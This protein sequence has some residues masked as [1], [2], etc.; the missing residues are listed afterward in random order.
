MPSWII[1]VLLAFLVL[2]LFVLWRQAVNARGEAEWSATQVKREAQEATLA[3]QRRSEQ[4]AAVLV[5]A[6]DPIV[7]LSHEPKILNLNPAAQALFG[8]QAALGQ[9]LMYATRSGEL[10]E[11]VTHVLAGGADHDRQVTIN[12]LPYRA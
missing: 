7:I 4:L 10:D 3:A 6:A 12:G 1:P 11:L 8:P 9:T 5:G 2:I